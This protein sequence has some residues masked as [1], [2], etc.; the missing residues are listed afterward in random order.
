MV[1]RM[2]SQS[3]SMFLRSFRIPQTAS[4]SKPVS[5]ARRDFRMMSRPSEEMIEASNR[6]SFSRSVGLFMSASYRLG[7]GLQEERDNSLNGAT[8]REFPSVNGTPFSNPNSLFASKWNWNWAC[9]KE[10][11]LILVTSLFPQSTT[12]VSILVDVNRYSSWVCAW[13]PFDPIAKIAF[14]AIIGYV[15]QNVIRDII[16]FHSYWSTNLTI[17]RAAWVSEVTDI[18]Y[19]SDPS[20]KTYP[21]R[22]I[23]II[24]TGW[25]GIGFIADP[26]LVKA[27][28][29]HLVCIDL[30]HDDTLP[31]DSRVSSI[32]VYQVCTGKFDVSGTPV[33]ARAS[34]YRS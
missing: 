24:W 22:E 33:P 25:A 6:T 1:V 18:E 7:P 31:F 3:L 19:S 28:G 16:Y 12:N 9:A 30:F 10:Q 27:A 5:I 11:A 13:I 21:I 2:F 26:F 29:S 20:S 8:N 23:R 14:A 32:V 4:E 17:D 15:C 34:P